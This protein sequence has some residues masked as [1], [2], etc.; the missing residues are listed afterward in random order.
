MVLRHTEMDTGS[1]KFRVNYKAVKLESRRI[2]DRIMS[3][4]S[5]HFF[6]WK[7]KMSVYLQDQSSHNI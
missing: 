2:A 7:M 5:I 4:L 6:L 3:L 1:D